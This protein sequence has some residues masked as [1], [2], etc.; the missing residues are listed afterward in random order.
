[1]DCTCNCTHVR[2]VSETIA[3]TYSSM[4]WM[5][6]NAES[7]Q[8]G[9][10]YLGKGGPRWQ[11]LVAVGLLHLLQMGHIVVQRAPL[12]LAAIEEVPQEHIVELQALGLRHCHLEDIALPEVGGQILQALSAPAQDHL[13]ST[14]LH[15]LH[16]SK[17]VMPT[18]GSADCSWERHP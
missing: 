17:V 11:L 15:L 7:V 10:G 5:L 13:V 3:G 6:G 8:H 12:S 18:A 2:H 1:M 16:C 14:K 4:K 9:S